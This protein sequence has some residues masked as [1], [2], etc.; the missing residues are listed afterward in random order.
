MLTYELVVAAAFAWLG[1]CF[2]SFLNVCIIRLPRGESIV[3][4]RSRCPRC[5]NQI[6]WYD[7]I[8]VVSW[9]L[10]GAKC[11]HCQ[12]PIS[13]QYPIIEGAAALIWIAAALLYGPTLR[14]V[15]GGVFGTVLLGAAIMESRHESLPEPYTIASLVLGLLLGSATGLYGLS[16][17]VVGAT[18]G[19]LI[20]FVVERVGDH[21]FGEGAMGAAYARMT[22]IIGAF[23]GAFVGWP[24]A[25]LVVL[26]AAILGGLT[27][28]I[29]ALMHRKVVPFGVFLAV[30]GG[31]VFVT[32]TA[33]T[34]WYMNF[35][36][37]A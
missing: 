17:A 27:N 29:L 5:H 7:N 19:F 9:L 25:V 33:I 13:A 22:A 18:I 6:A 15:A 23:I 34:K 36:G 37:A 28:G 32:G 16:S 1:L 24:G 12:L 2:G 30:A 10:L 31:I 26:A 35:L 3:T 20:L 8:P 14:A 4:P 21:F 11:R